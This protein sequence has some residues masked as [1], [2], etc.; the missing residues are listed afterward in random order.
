MFS[1]TDIC[2][3]DEQTHTYMKM[4]VYRECPGLFFKNLLL[5]KVS[6]KKGLKNTALG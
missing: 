2:S 1:E 4:H 6:R 5:L 3:V